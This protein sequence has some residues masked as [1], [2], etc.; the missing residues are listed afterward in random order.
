MNREY[1]TFSIIHFGTT[2]LGV[3]S[4][5]TARYCHPRRRTVF[6]KHQL[7]ELESPFNRQPYPTIA[8]RH[9]IASNIGLIEVQSHNNMLLD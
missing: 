3:D 9:N 6:T 1:S 8:E 4:P 7:S 2:Y 5:D